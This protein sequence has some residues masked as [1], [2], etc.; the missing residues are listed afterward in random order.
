MITFRI[1]YARG[2][3][4]LKKLE[5]PESSGGMD[6]LNFIQSAESDA[7]FSVQARLS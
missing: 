7:E 5:M 6:T 3:F 4:L 2:V 1:R